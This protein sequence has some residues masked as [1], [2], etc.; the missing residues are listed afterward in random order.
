MMIITNKINIATKYLRQLKKDIRLLTLNMDIIRE[1]GEENTDVVEREFRI[2]KSKF[3]L[4][5]AQHEKYRDIAYDIVTSAQETDDETKSLARELQD[6]SDQCRIECDLMNS[7]F[8]RIAVQHFK[9][10]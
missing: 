9:I 7:S 8:I 2:L 1:V 10:K 6:V 4:L 3:N 5:I